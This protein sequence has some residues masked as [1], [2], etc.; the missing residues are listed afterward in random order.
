MP[1]YQRRYSWERANW[2]A[3][4]R[5]I[6]E[7]YDFAASETAD[8]IPVTHFIGSFVLAPAPGAASAPA[9]FV[10]VDGQQRLTTTMVALAALRDLLAEDAQDEAGRSAVVAMYNTLFLHNAF[11][12]DP[13]RKLRLL[14]TQQDRPDYEA[15]VGRTPA[16]PK[17]RIGEAY[18]FFRSTKAMRGSDLQG[19]PLD[20][21]RINEILLSRLTLVEITTEAGDSVHRIFQTLNSAGVKLKQVDLLRNHFFM[22]LPTRGEILYNEVWRD[23]ELRLGEKQ[24][25]KFFWADLV[26]HDARVSRT[27]V[28]AAMQRRLEPIAHDEAAVENRLR[29]LNRDSVLFQAILRAE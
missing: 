25:D 19:M 1:L 18:D 21:P 4:W 11:E 20:L 5:S 12:V 16:Y 26:R 7:Q 13:M 24:L 28:Y 15:C 10:L 2:A 8:A 29:Q 6:L 14:P 23:M 9:R 3:F 27:D 17:G 22:L